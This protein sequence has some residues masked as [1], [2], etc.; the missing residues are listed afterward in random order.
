MKRR[1]LLKYMGVAPLGAGLSATALSA[2]AAPVRPD[3]GNTYEGAV[4]TLSELAGNAAPKKDYIKELGMRSFINAAGTYTAMTASIMHPDVMEAINAVSKAYIML[5]EVQDK[6]GARL[7]EICHAESATVTAGCWSAMVLGTAGVLTGMDPKK[8]A[9]LPDLTG[10]KN[11][12]LVQKSHNSGYVHAL[13][14]T[15]VRIQEIET[16]EELDAAVNADT[17]MLWFLNAHANLGKISYEEWV[18]AGKRHGIPTMIDIAAD[19]PPVENLWRFNDMGFDLVCISGGK[20]LRG[21]QSTGILMGR[22]DL[23]AAAR[24]SAPPR[25]GT[26]G[27]GMKVNKEEIVGLLAAVERYVA[28]DHE[29]EWKM[30]EDQVAYIA[31]TAKKRAGVET[32]VVVPP[33]ANHTPT[34][35]IRWD[36]RQ[37]PVTPQQVQLAL[38]NGNPSIEVLSNDKG[39]S[40]TVFMLREGEYKMVAKRIQEELLAAK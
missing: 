8:V 37:V 1:E 21:P 36:Q 32:E 25:G 17:A 31:A 30:W 23:I 4:N 40:L 9:Q 39:I 34:L 29:K 27:R 33:L 2:L 22:K 20:A 12:V 13:K 10:M 19:V 18:A 3:Q 14:N 24:L 38:R 15:G 11:T 28:T 7:A 26:I 5:D 6:V 16:I 35:N